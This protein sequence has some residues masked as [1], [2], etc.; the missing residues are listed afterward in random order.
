MEYLARYKYL[1]L[2]LVTATSLA[3]FFN[4]NHSLAED[5]DTDVPPA[6][7]AAAPSNKTPPPADVIPPKNTGPGGFDIF[8]VETKD[9]GP[10]TNDP[11][12]AEQPLFQPD[13]QKK[14]IVGGTES[15]PDDIL[16][17]DFDKTKTTAPGTAAGAVQPD[18]DS[19]PVADAPA[20]TT[21]VADSKYSELKNHLTNFIKNFEDKKLATK[22]PENKPA[23][24]AAP[25][26]PQQTANATA[27]NAN[28]AVPSTDDLFGLDDKSKTAAAPVAPAPLDSTTAAPGTPAAAEPV[29][30][31]QPA[32][33]STETAAA[34]PPAQP[35][36]TTPTTA[37]SAD[38]PLAEFANA[39]A[40]NAAPAAPAPAT[41]AQPVADVAPAVPVIT[42]PAPVEVAPA[43]PKPAEIAASTPE[44]KPAT[45]AVA[46]KIEEKPAVVAEKVAE[47]TEEVKP[48]AAE[49]A[50]PETAK[51]AEKKAKPVISPEDK[52]Y[53]A[54][55]DKKMQNLPKN[56]Q[57]SDSTL[58]TIDKVTPSIIPEKVGKKLPPESLTIDKSDN[59]EPLNEKDG[60]IRSTKNMD[61]SVKK[62][63]KKDKAVENKDKLD[64]AYRA[65][66]AGQIAAAISIYKDII[67]KNPDN[68]DALF[69]LATAY[70]RNSQYDQARAIYTE[71]LEKDPNNK[72]VLNNFLVLVA[73]ES[74]ESALIELEKLERLNS[75]FS[76]ISAQIAMIY[77]KLNQPEKAERYLRRAVLL[78]PENVTYK[79]NLAITSDKLG[80]EQQAA[81]LYSQILEAVRRGAIIPGDPDK[82]MDRLSYLEQKLSTSN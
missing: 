24:A 41:P 80:K 67:D 2:L 47:K 55:L 62:T 8:D 6:T 72:E 9:V 61:I 43:A 34:T 66:L 25:S 22:T 12:S 51:K 82:I 76:P 68:K 73:E 26:A 39:P 37:I 54:S 70:H 40:N 71:I 33:S 30:T 17:S 69:G 19:Q 63:A 81:R 53:I 50:K 3:L 65:L 44:A 38:N 4:T 74:P 58:S 1:L 21:P 28:A 42:A 7:A 77:L 75:S 16:E 36:P 57:L 46:P 64:T 11:T 48:A 60:I 79:Y 49:K 52:E 31:P 10:K 35:A 5:V 32:P 45:E 56:K 23:D 78:S 18:T 15:G 13:L 59:S 27:P 14:D 29:A 20:T